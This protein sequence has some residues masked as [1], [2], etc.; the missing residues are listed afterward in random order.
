MIRLLG[1]LYLEDVDSVADV[2]EVYASF[3][4]TVELC[5]MGNIGNIAHPLKL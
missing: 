5:M 4:F 2:S 3:I 1:W